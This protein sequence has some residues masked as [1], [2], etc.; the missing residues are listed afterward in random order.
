MLATLKKLKISSSSIEKFMALFTYHG[1]VQNEPVLNTML[2]NPQQPQIQQLHQPPDSV[3]NQS[4][5]AVQTLPSQSIP[6][7]S[8]ILD[9][10][11]NSLVHPNITLQSRSGTP[12]QVRRY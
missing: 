4:A 5:P 8:I 1:L 7:N 3:Q 2:T 6:I 9:P 11:Q 10:P 12:P